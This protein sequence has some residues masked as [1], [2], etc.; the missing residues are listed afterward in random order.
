MS[1]ATDQVNKLL[2]ER[3]KKCSLP[4]H[5][6]HDDDEAGRPTCACRLNPGDDRPTFMAKPVEIRALVFRCPQC[7]EVRWT[8]ETHREIQ[9]GCPAGCWPDGFR[10]MPTRSLK[11]I[12]T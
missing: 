6:T 5:R 4:I 8:H 10:I 7:G 3:C 2:G 11:S 1:D 9:P 12:E